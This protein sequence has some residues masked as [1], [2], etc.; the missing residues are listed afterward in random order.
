MEEY[1]HPLHDEDDAVMV[2]TVFI[3]LCAVVVAG[4]VIV[5]IAIARVML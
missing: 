1:M 2:I 5:G 4:F 3:G